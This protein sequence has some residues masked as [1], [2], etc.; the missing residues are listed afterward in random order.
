VRIK[1]AE[2]EAARLALEKLERGEIVIG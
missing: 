1:I 2:N